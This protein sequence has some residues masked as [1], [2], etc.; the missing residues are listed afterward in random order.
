MDLELTGKVAIVSGGSRGIGK[1]AARALAAEGVDVAITARDMAVAN[2]AAAEL[3]RESGRKVQ[4]FASDTGKD[5]AVRGAVA[6]IM[7][8]FGRVDILVNSA[9]NPASQARAPKLAD[10]TDEPF[11]DEMNI[12]VL[13][14][15][16]MAREVA[17][18]M[19]RQGWGRIINISGLNARLSGNI[20]GSIRNVGVAA[21]T[22]NL[23]DELGSSGIG[24][25]CVHPGLTRTEKTPAMLQR[26]A[27]AAG[28]TPEEQER[29]IT[30][31]I[32]IGRMPTALRPK[33]GSDR[34]LAFSP[35]GQG[36]G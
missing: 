19:K 29:R 21:L 26:Q 30:S 12:K 3:A 1:E 8:A 35:A 6:A 4:A 13:G 27:V 9:A 15:L 17:P 32:V 11:F 23:A 20:I 2:E 36:A 5:E 33:K 31:R 14:Y 24:V 10:I 22:K 28:I 18:H 25:T 16:R 34:V 7:K